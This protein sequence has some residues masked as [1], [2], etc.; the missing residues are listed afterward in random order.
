M[1]DIRWIRENPEMFDRALK[2]RGLA[3]EAKRDI[4]LDNRLEP[5]FGQAVPSQ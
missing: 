3:P 4:F 5:H 1:H 2:R